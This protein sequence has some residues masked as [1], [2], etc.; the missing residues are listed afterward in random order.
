MNNKDF[1]L[2]IVGYG[3]IGKLVSNIS[4]ANLKKTFIYTGRSKVGIGKKDICT[5]HGDLNSLF[6]IDLNNIENLV[7]VYCAG[8][9]K[10]EGFSRSE[11]FNYA[12]YIPT[13]F[14]SFLNESNLKKVKFI[15][16]ST[17][18][19]FND[20]EIQPTASSRMKVLFNDDP[21]VEAKKKLDVFIED[22]KSSKV[23][24]VNLRLSNL[25]TSDHKTSQ[26]KILLRLAKKISRGEKVSLVKDAHID[27]ISEIQL[28]NA[29]K[30]EILNEES[31]ISKNVVNQKS[32]N[33]CDLYN[34]YIKLHG[35]NLLPGSYEIIEDDKEKI[36]PK[37]MSAYPENKI[38]TIN[39]FA[40][41]LYRLAGN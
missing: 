30:Q 14:L 25:I 17:M 9:D 40:K 24:C 34:E 8:P 39:F 11:F 36:I 37:Y 4:N 33:L 18:I 31:N 22:F 29:I 3:A 20:E 32:Y 26:R 12:Y 19:G 7:V 28:L 35:N 38:E 41:E 15:H 5:F 2:L 6:K 23:L 1:N 16:L 27:I 10:F 13:K 21:Y